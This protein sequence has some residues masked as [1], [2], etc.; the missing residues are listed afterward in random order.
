MKGVRLTIKNYR[1][2]TDQEPARL[3]FRPGLTALLGKN[4]AGKS[5]LKP[6][7]YEFRELFNVLLQMEPG[8]KPGLL[9]MI[10]GGPADVNYPGVVDPVEIFNNTNERPIILEIEIIDPVAVE[11]NCITQMRLRCGR[12]NPRRWTVEAFMKG[13]R[14]ITAPSG[15]ARTAPLRYSDLPLNF[16]PAAIRVSADFTPSSAGGATGDR[17]SWSGLRSRSP[18]A[19]NVAA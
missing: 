18:V 1:G 19:V 5:S 6:F 16:H 12:S 10:Q 2:F 8:S 11:E 17:R 15:F 14:K 3:E 9:S 7:F 4:N 13:G